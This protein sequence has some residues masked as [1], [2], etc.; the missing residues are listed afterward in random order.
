MPEKIDEKLLERGWLHAHEE[1][2]PEQRVFRPDNYPLPPSRGRTGYEFRPG[3][4]VMKRVPGPTDRHTSAQGTWTI[5]SEGRVT[6]RIPGAPEEVIDID[7][8]TADRLVTKK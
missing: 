6:I 2:T 3:G 8:L 4:L 7:V 1:D 5:N